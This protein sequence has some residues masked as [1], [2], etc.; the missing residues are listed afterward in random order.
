MPLD[1]AQV[2]HQEAKKMLE[3]CANFPFFLDLRHVAVDVIRTRGKVHPLEYF[4]SNR[5]VWRFPAWN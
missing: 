2:V 4:P 5:C 3:S 1:P